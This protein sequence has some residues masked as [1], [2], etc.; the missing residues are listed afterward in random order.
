MPS[1]GTAWSRTFRSRWYGAGPLFDGGPY[2]ITNLVQLLGPVSRVAAVASKAQDVRTIGSGP[3]AGQRFE[4]TV[5][6]HVTAVFEFG[7][8]ASSQSIF[9]RGGQHLHSGAPAA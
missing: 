3:R 7:S 4:V 1:A 2:H 6:T 5:P 9:G 8:G